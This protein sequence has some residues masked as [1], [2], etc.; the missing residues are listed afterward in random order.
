MPH[1]RI[2]DCLRK[3]IPGCKTVDVIFE[4]ETSRA[5]YKNLMTCGSV[6]ICAVC[7]A[8][9]T[10]RRAAELQQAVTK[11]HTEGGFVAMM[12][13]TLR[14]DE[15][16]PLKLLVEALRKSHRDFKVGAPFQ[17]IKDRFCWHGS[18]AAMEVTH[19]ESGWHPHLHELVFFE[20]MSPD[21]WKRFRQDAKSRWLSSLAKCGRN[22]SWEHGLD[23]RE[24]DQAVYDYIAK[25][26]HEPQDGGWTLDREIAKAPVKEAHQDGRTPFQFLLD[27]GAGD[28]QAGKLFQEYAA[29][30]KGKKQLVWSRGLRD[31]LSM[32]PEQADEQIAEELPETYVTLLSLNLW[33]WRQILALPDEIHAL[34]LGIAHYGEKTML[35]EFLARYGIDVICDNGDGHTYDDSA[36]GV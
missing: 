32:Q 12:T 15:Y 16:D 35:V 11:W 22:A 24:G 6:W 14:H 1:E 25:F 19:G 33:Q 18:V 31:E 3:P 13:Y 4:P 5:H 27:Y 36:A 34:L 9:I 2:H 28:K 29:V 17:R 23:I 7:A 21:Q 20:P 30:F 8:R 26:G 10:E